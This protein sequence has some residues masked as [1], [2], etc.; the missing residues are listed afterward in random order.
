MLDN[1]LD[2][3]SHNVGYKFCKN[4]DHLNGANEDTIEFAEKLYSKDAGASYAKFYLDELYQD[5]L[6][7]I[8][9]PK[10]EFLIEN[11]GHEIGDVFDFGCGL[12]HMVNIMCDMGLNAKGGDVSETLVYHGNEAIFKKSGSKPLELIPLRQSSL[13]I[14]NLNVDVLCLMAVMEHISDLNEFFDAVHNSNFNYIYYSVPTYGLSVAI[15]GAFP[16]VFPRHLSGGHTHLFTEKSLLT[17]NERL[18]VTPLAEWRFGTDIQDLRRS[19][20]INLSKNGASD[21][22]LKRFDH[23]FSSYIDD[24]QGVV[25]TAHNCSQIHVIAKRL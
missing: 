9:R 10:V 23:E 5:R 19:M 11:L 12:G 7:H 6:D 25:D 1:C 21:S 2:F 13:F 17:L 14:R 24:L 22:F 3:K 20:Y 4:C 16:D 15:E 18:G 8:Y